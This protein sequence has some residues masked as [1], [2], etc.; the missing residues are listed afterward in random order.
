MLASNSH[1]SWLLGSLGGGGGGG[2]GKVVPVDGGLS[3]GIMRYLRMIG[4]NRWPGEKSL[5]LSPHSMLVLLFV[6]GLKC[7]LI[8]TE[9]N[10][11]PR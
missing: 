5:A 10:K 2:A 4:C 1:L 6:F 8:R 11:P 7:C 9:L 3:M